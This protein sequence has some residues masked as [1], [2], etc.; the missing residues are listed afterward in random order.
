MLNRSRKVD[1]EVYYNADVY[2][3]RVKKEESVAYTEECENI[4]PVIREKREVQVT[5]VTNNSRI[6][7]SL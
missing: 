5:P 7:S 4:L 3:S 6:N 2:T 1:E